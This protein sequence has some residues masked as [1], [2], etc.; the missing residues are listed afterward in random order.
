MKLP[1]NSIHKTARRICLLSVAAAITLLAANQRSQAVSL[2][3]LYGFGAIPDPGY[4]PISK[5]FLAK[6][7]N[8]YGTCEGAGQFEGT[9]LPEG[10]VWKMTPSGDVTMFFTFHGSDGRTPNAVI[11]GS[12]GNFYGTTRYDGPSGGGTV[13][14]LTPGGT[15]T[16][17]Y[18]FSTSGPTGGQ[19]MAGLVEGKD[20]NF[21]GT[22]STGGGGFF[23][24]ISGTIFKITP[25]GTLTTL[26]DFGQDF[27]ETDGANPQ[28]TLVLGTDGNFYGTAQNGGGL[29]GNGT[30]F[31]ITPAGSFTVLHAFDITNDG[32]G[33]Y[34][35]SGG[36]IQ[37]SDGDFYGVTDRGGSAELGVVYRISSSGDYA[38]L[39]SIG[40]NDGASPV[41]ELA[42]GID[43]NFY[44]VTGTSVASGSIYKITPNGEFT[45]LHYFEDAA[46]E[47]ESPMAGLTRDADGNFYGTTWVSGPALEGTSFKLIIN[48]VANLGNISTRLSVGTGDNVLIGGFIVTGTQAK[49]VI[50]RGIGPSLPLSGALAD[51]FLELHDSTGATIASNDNWKDSTNK[52]AIIDSTIAPSNDKEPAVL[53]TLDPGAY[54]AVVRGVNNT[55]GIALVEAYDLAA[56]VDAKLANI[57]TRGLVQT[58]DNVMIGGLII[59]NDSARDVIVRAIGPSLGLDGALANPFLELHNSDGDL[60]AS[61]DDWRSDQEAEIIATTI[62]PTNDKESAIVATLDP[63]AYTAIVHGVNNT[64]GVALVEV[65]DL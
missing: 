26:H 20:G 49:K 50:V 23:N 27:E 38:V 28:A 34:E 37:G 47:G 12:D 55:T 53:A 33:G 5:L 31:K 43:G 4:N 19:P 30:V 51:P 16:T 56:G 61:N 44:G 60:I 57:S 7:G 25:S 21:Y 29:N 11:Q 22:T 32:V 41:G 39:H 3:V 14:K 62:P 46:D 52:Q 17:L 10:T 54:T 2:S 24:G 58:G 42:E 8:F 63:G 64:T 1:F 45:V 48:P 40:S 13:F 15:L 35:P 6:D 65:Y 36:V 59:F 9:E 18:R